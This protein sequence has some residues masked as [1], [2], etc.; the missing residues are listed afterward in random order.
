MPRQHIPESS[1]APETLLRD[2]LRA[3]AGAAPPLRITVV[4]SGGI[5]DT[6]L[7]LPTLALLRRFF[8]G[9]DVT[10]VGSAWAEQ[11]LPLM[12][13]P[14]RT[15]LFGSPELTPVFSDAP[16]SDP[17]GVFEQ[18]GLVLIYT[19]DS[20][21]SLVR[22]ARRLACG[23]VLT[24]PVEP[25]GRVSAALHFSSA[26]LND[27]ATERDIPSARLCVRSSTLGWAEKWL[28]GMRESP[29]SLLAAI[30][31]GSG[32]RKKCWPAALFAQII[33]RLHGAGVR[34]ILIEGPA[35][36]QCCAEIRRLCPAEVVLTSACGMSLER[37]AVIVS[38]CDFYVGNDSGITHLAAALGVPALAIFGPTDPAVWAPRASNCLAV[39]GTTT[40][41]QA[42]D[43]EWPTCEEVLQG[44]KSVTGQELCGP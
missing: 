19:S 9:C 10:L 37:I 41:R 32:G 24:W 22:S 23:P 12:P 17:A 18:A 11:L 27:V 36:G 43:R 33:Q 25:V 13:D 14:P 42:R 31:P 7:V 5:G 28:W 29:G 2:S 21:G 40:S 44:L 1:L 16:E 4:R 15:V 8:G 38:S 34:T 20:S 6:V 30:H 39:G 26:L 3:L 35:D